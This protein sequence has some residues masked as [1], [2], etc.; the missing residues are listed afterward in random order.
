MKRHVNELLINSCANFK[1]LCL[2]RTVPHAGNIC[3]KKLGLSHFEGRESQIGG[4][5]VR[6]KFSAKTPKLLKPKKRY[7]Q[8]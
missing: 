1:Q 4:S 7:S 2:E 8:A 3:F 6:R 5:V